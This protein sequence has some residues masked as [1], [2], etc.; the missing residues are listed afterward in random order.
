MTTAAIKI[1]QKGQ[2]TIPKEIR[3][4]L[5]TSAVYFEVLNDV[6]MVRPVRDAASSLSAYKHN[7]KPGVAILIKPGCRH[8]AVGKLRILNMPIP[9]FDPHDEWFDEQ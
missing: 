3:D 5:K 8:R 9:S 2:V 6:V 7:V 4:R 1:T